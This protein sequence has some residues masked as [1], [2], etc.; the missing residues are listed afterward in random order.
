MSFVILMLGSDTELPH[1]K[2]LGILFK[3]SPLEEDSSS[4]N[5]VSSSAN[6][7]TLSV[8]DA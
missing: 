5:H 6:E 1:P 7:M 4:E 2:Q 8:L 3:K